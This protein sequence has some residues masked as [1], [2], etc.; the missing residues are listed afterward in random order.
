[1]QE[2]AGIARHSSLRG[3]S[4]SHGWWD[5]AK[6]CPLGH[7]VGWATP[8][9]CPVPAGGPCP[10]GQPPELGRHGV[11]L[12]QNSSGLTLQQGQS[13]Q[14]VTASRAPGK[15]KCSFHHPVLS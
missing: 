2:C 5:T 12:H 8:S 4:P 7:C 6:C 1:M 10:P 11:M 15:A 13:L 3:S 9:H 14:A